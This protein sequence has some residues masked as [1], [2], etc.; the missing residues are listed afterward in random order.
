MDVSVLLHAKSLLLTF[1][2][3]AIDEEFTSQLKLIEADL[4]RMV[5]IFSSYEEQKP[6]LT[7]AEKDERN[8]V[9]KLLREALRLLRDDFEQQTK[10]F[11]STSRGAGQWTGAGD[12][13]MTTMMT[14]T[15]N[16]GFSI[17]AT[18]NNGAINKMGQH[19]PNDNISLSRKKGNQ[20]DAL[21]NKASAK[22]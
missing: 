10:Q 13:P 20:N 15:S 21:A 4:K 1:F 11:G 3:I 16:T 14:D 6:D 2:P 8:A 7:Q 9:I 12:D 22:R 19:N 17:N 5:T 18:G